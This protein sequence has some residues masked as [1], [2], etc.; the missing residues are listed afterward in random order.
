[1]IC[2]RCGSV[3]GAG[4]RCLHCG[5]N[6]A[7]YKKI[8]RTSNAYYNAG[9]EKAKVRDLSGAVKDLTRALE[10]DKKNIP[11]R[12]LLGLVFY[13]IGETVEALCHWVVSKNLQPKNNPAD[14][15]LNA[16]R[17]DRR[18]LEAM[19]QAIKGYN[20]ALEQAAHDGEDLAVIQLRSVISAHPHFVKAYELLALLY[21][22]D[23]EYSKAGKLLKKALT[24]DKGNVTC[25]RYL[26]EITG[27]VSKRKSKDRIREERFSEEQLRLAGEEVLVPTY[28]EKSRVLQFALGL[29]L[30]LAI[31]VGSYF[32][33][34]RPAVERSISTDMNQYEIS[35]KERIENKDT[36]IERL[37]TELEAIKE[38]LAVNK[39]QMEI[40]IGEDGSITNYNRI[41]DAMVLYREEKW[42]DLIELYSKINP[43]VVESSSF[44]SVY[45]QIGTFLNSD[46]L[47]D[48]IMDEGV[49]AFNKYKYEKCRKICQR[50]LDKNPDYVKAL[51]YMAM[52]YEAQGNDKSAAEY[53]KEIVNRFPESEY[54]KAA[55][56]RLH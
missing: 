2:Y 13:E 32:F 25:R 21:I 18:Q 40:Y 28:K 49:E 31:C 33:L 26:Q 22:H 12:N 36:D 5:A 19:N 4:K 17:S 41:L 8:I 52:S 15:Y 56:K 51:Y 42:D 16:V 6:I 29:G 27:K 30:G 9:L 55:Y 11:A 23:E 50:C 47:L 43:A 1:M 14:E 10:Y 3:L 48:K 7:I 37:Q 44:L 53:F 46:E 20:Q 35:Y 38:E 39:R 54:Y 45:D 34:I 24:I